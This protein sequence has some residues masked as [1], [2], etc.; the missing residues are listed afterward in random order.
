MN[1]I[2]VGTLIREITGQ[3][4]VYYKTMLAFM[5]Q[6]GLQFINTGTD[7][8]VNPE[9]AEE[10]KVEWAKYVTPP[11]PPTRPSKFD[12]MAKLDALWQ[13]S[14]AQR[15]ELNAAAVTIE[16]FRDEITWLKERVAQLETLT[17]QV[18]PLPVVATIQPYNPTRPSVR[19]P[20]ILV[21]GFT[22][23]QF[24]S[25]AEETGEMYD[26]EHI[27]GDNL[28]RTKLPQKVERVLVLTKFV[29]H[30]GS[31]RVKAAYNKD[32][33]IWCNGAASLAKDLL[34]ENVSATP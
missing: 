33:I 10:V 28:I 13:A 7:I 23:S 11:T 20:R 14:E 19:K 8:F 12:G 30:A 22:P 18:S 3:K 31:D 17:R 32:Q 16:A 15:Q 5:E 26:L 9:Q 21:I 34:L 27:T 24:A 29:G 25:L 1:V 4:K 2:S 6:A